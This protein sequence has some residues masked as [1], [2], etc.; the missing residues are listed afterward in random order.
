MLLQGKTAVVYGA[1][2]HV[3]GAVARAFAGE[4]A[5]V[6]LGGRTVAT[7]EAVA[8][9]IRAA[10]GTAEAAQVDALNKE[11]VEAHLGAVVKQS[12]RVDVSLNAVWIRGDLQGAPLLELSGDDFATPVL[13][14]IRTHFLT[15]TAAARRMTAQG[16]GVVLTLSSSS[17]ALSGRD[18]R[19]HKTGGFSTACA[20][21]KAFSRSL[22]G[23]V[24][25]RGVRVVCLRPDALPE[26]WGEY[27]E[28]ERG[29]GPKGGVWRYMED[30][31]ALGRLPTL[32]EVADAAVFAASDRAG[33]LTGTVLNLS[34]GS[35]M[36]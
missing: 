6:H 18:R 19:F 2:G 17:S 9:E 16:S 30:G 36:E 21:A 32:P 24:G 3:G 27:D 35:V 5:S 12:G 22:A 20:A 28:V 1:G 15:A 33:A 10:G 23:E 29:N 13:S 4:G 11:A 25:P 14:A 26:S 7:L 34:C 31:T 8:E